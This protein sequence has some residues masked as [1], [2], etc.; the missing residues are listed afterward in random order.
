[1][2]KIIVLIALL[3]AVGISPKTISAHNEVP[4]HKLSAQ[5]ARADINAADPDYRV[6]AL[7]NIFKKYNSPL[8]GQAKYYVYYADKHGIDWKLLPSIAGLE[9]TFGRFLMPGSYNAY[10][11]GGGHIYFDSW[12]DGIDTIASA[13]RKNY[14]ARGADTIYEIGPIYAE[15]DHWPATVTKFSDEINL[16]YIRLQ[17][18]GL[19][20]TI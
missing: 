19:E 1:M 9:S 2:N 16:E 10:G 8:Q 17:S 7:E 11:W 3:L 18:T 13:L 15:A 4:V 14:Y 20:Y 12:E 6:V 5:L